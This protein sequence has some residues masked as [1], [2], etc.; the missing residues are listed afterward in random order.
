MHEWSDDPNLNLN[1][2]TPDQNLLNH[3]QHALCNI[4][5]HVLA[6]PHDKT[7]PNSCPAPPRNGGRDRPLPFASADWLISIAREMS[8]WQFMSLDLY[9]CLGRRPPEAN[10]VEGR[11]FRRTSSNFCRKWTK[12]WYRCIEFVC[13]CS[14]GTHVVTL[15]K[16]SGCTA[17]ALGEIYTWPWPSTEPL[18]SRLKVRFT[19]EYGCF[20]VIMIILSGSED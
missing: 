17:A 6:K 4:I 10:E 11:Y 19:Q 16:A 13:T 3:F 20:G 2:C 15:N 9:V 8:Y 18:I 5:I 14:K 12:T 1:Q 7:G